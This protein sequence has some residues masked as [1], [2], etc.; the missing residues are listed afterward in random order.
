MRGRVSDIGPY[1]FEQISGAQS[2]SAKE[3]AQYVKLRGAWAIYRR[4]NRNFRVAGPCNRMVSHDRHV[5]ARRHATVS[6]GI[7]I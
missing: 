1:R 6:E 2:A 7:E 4:C 3:Y 5:A